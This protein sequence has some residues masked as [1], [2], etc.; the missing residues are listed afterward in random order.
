VPERSGNTRQNQEG[1]ASSTRIAFAFLSRTQS[2]SPHQELGHSRLV[3]V[4]LQAARCRLPAQLTANPRSASECLRRA[5]AAAAA[6][7]L[8]LTASTSASSCR[9]S[10]CGGRLP[11]GIARVGWSWGFLVVS[12]HTSRPGFQVVVLQEHVAHW[13]QDSGVGHLL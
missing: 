3:V 2:Y 8:K 10:G 9:R 12:V 5:A 1:W 13:V 6:A 11:P 4:Q 7:V